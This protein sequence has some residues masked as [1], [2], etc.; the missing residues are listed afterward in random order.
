MRRITPTGWANEKGTPV[1]QLG[2][3]EAVLKAMGW[4]GVLIVA[5]ADAGCRALEIWARA[6]RGEAIRTVPAR[7]GPALLY[8]IHPD[9]IIGVDVDAF[10]AVESACWADMQRILT[11]R[12]KTVHWA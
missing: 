2:S 8:E 1:R 6:N 3:T 12:F 5:S 9:T 4:N 10:V 11:R 7:G